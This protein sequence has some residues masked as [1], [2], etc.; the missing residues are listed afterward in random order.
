MCSCGCA[1]FLPDASL[2]LEDVIV[3]LSIGTSGKSSHPDGFSII[4]L[5]ILVV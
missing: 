3:S 1:H 2:S 5:F 4:G